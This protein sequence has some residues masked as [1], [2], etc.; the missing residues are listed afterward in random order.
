MDEL[1]KKNS[2]PEDIQESWYKFCRSMQAHCVDNSGIATMT[3]EIGIIQTEIISWSVKGIEKIYPSKLADDIEFSD[4]G[5]AA[6]IAHLSATAK[7]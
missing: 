6:L 7:K 5:V 4:K 2:I 1:E 3:V